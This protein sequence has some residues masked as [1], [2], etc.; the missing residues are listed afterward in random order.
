MGSIAGAICNMDYMLVKGRRAQLW[1]AMTLW[2]R[3]NIEMSQQESI[4]VFTQAK[5]FFLNVL[6]A[7]V[8]TWQNKPFHWVD[9]IIEN[10]SILVKDAIGNNQG[11]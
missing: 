1:K 6:P 7:I 2:R 8:K 9:I 4:S 11:T 10:M 5:E 3:R